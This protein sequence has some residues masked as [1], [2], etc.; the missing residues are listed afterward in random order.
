[1]GFLDSVKKSAAKTKKQS[2]IVL[3]DREIAS[4][5]RAFGV[6]LYDLLA[7]AVYS[8]H[9]TPALLKKQPEVASAFDKFAKEIRTHEAEKEAKIKEIEICDVKKDTRLPATNAKEK[10]GNFSKY[11]GDTTQS[12]KLRADVVMLGRSIKQKK[13]AFGVDIFDQVVLSSDNT[14]TAGWRQA[15]TS[16]VNKQI[17]S[18][19]DKAKQNVSVPM[20]KKETKTREIAL[21]DQE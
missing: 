7:G 15:M 3:L 1:M 5:Q 17:A 9:A 12:T 10:L 20:S 11:L 8:G 13:E 21:L 18:A 14:N 6:T 2:E 19:I 4:I 16:A